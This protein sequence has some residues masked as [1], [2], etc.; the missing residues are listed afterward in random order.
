MAFHFNPFGYIQRHVSGQQ[1]PHKHKK[2]WKVYPLLFLSYPFNELAWSCTDA[3]LAC[4]Q[5]SNHSLITHWLYVR[6]FSKTTCIPIVLCH[7][8][9]ILLIWDLHEVICE[10]CDIA[11]KIHV[12]SSIFSCLKVPM[13]CLT[14]IRWK[15]TAMGPWPPWVFARAFRAWVHLVSPLPLM[16]PPNTS[17]SS[18]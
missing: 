14:V 9:Y 11:N 8:K 7:L 1:F 12:T 5:W 15:Y 6:S 17:M 2:E 10:C 18:W 4:C 13:F 16:R 3:I